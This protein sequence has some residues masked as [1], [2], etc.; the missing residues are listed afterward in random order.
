MRFPRFGLVLFV[1]LLL[2]AVGAACGSSNN[3]STF[4]PKEDASVS[5]GNVGDGSGSSSGGGDGPNLLKDASGGGDASGTLAISPANKTHRRPVRH[6]GADG[7]VH[8]ERGRA[9]RRPRRSPSTS[10]QI[11]TIGAATGVMTP[12]GRSAAPR[13]SPRRSA[14]QKVST[15]ITVIVHLADN[16]APAGTTPAAARAATAA[17]A[18][19]A[20][21]AR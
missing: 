1:C 15:T 10:A 18:A 21:A 2:A 19:R 7:D 6:A 9:E 13:T 5:D 17:S 16:G 20:P 11:G 3:S 8:G 4:S 14:A 12:T